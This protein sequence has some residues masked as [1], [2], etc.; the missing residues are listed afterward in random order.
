MFPLKHMLNQIKPLF[1]LLYLSAMGLFCVFAVER[2]MNEPFSWMAGGTFMLI[3]FSVYAMNRYT[4]M[5]EDFTTDI[6]RAL[7]FSKTRYIFKISVGAMGL[8]LVLLLLAGKLNFFYLLLASVGTLYSFYL[9]PWYQRGKGLVFLRIKNI[10][11]LKNFTVA[12][13]WGSAIF[14]IPMIHASRYE[15]GTT[16]LYILALSFFLSTLNNTLFDDIRDEI[17]DR[18]AEIKTVPTVFG[19]KNSYRFLYSINLLWL[20]CIPVLLFLKIIDIKHAIFLCGMGGYP[21]IYLIAHQKEKLTQATLDF[22]AEADLLIYAGG[23]FAL[24][25]LGGR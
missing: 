3:V 25:F 10:L 2:Y 20:G 13:L 17:G 23:L 16:V 21:F 18:M 15:S 14:A 4:D 5:R 11:F 6:K 12:F 24:S 7:F 22:L 8:S 9:I 1:F 19:L